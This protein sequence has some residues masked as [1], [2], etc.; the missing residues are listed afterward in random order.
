MEGNQ[1][2][3]GA[4]IENRDISS[5]YTVKFILQYHGQWGTVLSKKNVFSQ[6]YRP[7]QMKI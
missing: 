5:A 6:G 7:I 4:N 2:I 1:S 3:M